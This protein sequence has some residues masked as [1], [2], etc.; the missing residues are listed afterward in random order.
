M[1]VFIFAGGVDVR[2][3]S[4]VGGDPFR[5]GARATGFQ[6]FVLGIVQGITQFLRSRPPAP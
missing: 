5:F 2:S 1:Y 6:A 3:K 4:C